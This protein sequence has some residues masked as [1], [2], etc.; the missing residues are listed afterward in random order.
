MEIEFPQASKTGVEHDCFCL[1][2]GAHEM[3]GMSLSMDGRLYGYT[4]V[5]HA[6]N[7]TVMLRRVEFVLRL[8]IVKS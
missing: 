3:L 2:I 1:G 8:K 4:C 6:G 7:E 5:E